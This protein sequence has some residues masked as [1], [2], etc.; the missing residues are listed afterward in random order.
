M[1]LSRAI[2]SGVFDTLLRQI[3]SL[4]FPFESKARLAAVNRYRVLCQPAR[5]K[6]PKPM[7][8]RAETIGLNSKVFLDRAIKLVG[9]ENLIITNRK[10]AFRSLVNVLYKGELELHEKSKKLIFVDVRTQKKYRSC[11]EAIKGGV[12]DKLLLQTGVIA[13]KSSVFD[14]AYDRYRKITQASRQAKA[15][16][17][18]SSSPLKAKATP[19]DEPDMRTTMAKPPTPP[20]ARS[21]YVVKATSRGFN[22]CSNRIRGLPI[23]GEGSPSTRDSLQGLLAAQAQFDLQNKISPDSRK[24]VAVPKNKLVAGVNSAKKNEGKFK[25]VSRYPK[26]VNKENSSSQQKV[27]FSPNVASFHPSL[28]P[29]P[30]NGSLNLNM[31]LG[32]GGNL[33]HTTNSA[34]IKDV[35]NSVKLDKKLDCGTKR[36]RDGTDV[37]SLAPAF[38]SS[39]SSRPKREQRKYE[40]KPKRR[41]DWQQQ[42]WQMD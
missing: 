16:R 39:P 11:P 13:L 6:A 35:T 14:V 12:L 17:T 9:D 4:C 22:G 18:S 3:G 30:Q 38:N 5:K 29:T 10:K 7:E 19:L 20:K 27:L 26:G 37:N 40:P 34:T 32:V 8:K 23:G 24:G 28:N 31:N 21:P 1:Q 36:S 33:I 15:A 2:R 25:Q 41:N 42:F